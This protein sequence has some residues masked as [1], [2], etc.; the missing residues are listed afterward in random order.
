MHH[1]RQRPTDIVAVDSRQA[2]LLHEFLIGLQILDRRVHV[3]SGSFK[4]NHDDVRRRQQACHLPALEVG[5]L[6]GGVKAHGV[7]VG[8]GAV[9]DSGEGGGAGVAGGTAA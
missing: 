6:T 8:V 9:L 3:V 5:D 1:L 4:L 7:E 2:R